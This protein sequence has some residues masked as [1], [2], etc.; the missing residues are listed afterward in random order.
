MAQKKET[1]K[2]SNDDKIATALTELTTIVKSISDR[3]EVT[4]NIVG[5]VL[6][7]LG[8]GKEIEK[9]EKSVKKNKTIR[10]ESENKKIVDYVEKMMNSKKDTDDD[11]AYR[12]K[13]YNHE[14]V[15]KDITGILPAICKKG[16]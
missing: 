1:Q 11:N 14:K 5:D 10:N 6:K 15:I 16:V 4:E 3:Q 12:G 13:G 2:S 8:V 9:V 7:G